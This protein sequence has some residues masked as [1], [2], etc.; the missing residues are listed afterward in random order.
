MCE[1]GE[2]MSTRTGQRRP[3]FTLVE[4]LVV[5]SII[6]ILVA[7]IMPG[8]GKAKEKARDIRCR[9]NLR[10]LQIGA[11]NYAVDNSLLLPTA[12]GWVSGT[13]PNPWW[14]PEGTNDIRNGYL[15]PYVGSNYSVYVCPSF[16]RPDIVGST[17][18]DGTPFDWVNVRPVRSYGMN[19][20]LDAGA[21]Q[22]FYSGGSGYQSSRWLLFADVSHTN[23]LPDGTLFC[24]RSLRSDVSLYYGW[25]EQ[26]TMSTNTS[27]GVQY[28]TIGIL[29]GGKG[30][31][32]FLDGHVES[33]HWSES[34]SAWRG[35]R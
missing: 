28:E 8:I 13:Q 24:Q 2:G 21:A 17:A 26:L 11:M 22:A 6:G 9:N 7:L 18:P 35:E 3:A 5:I 30:N 31:V 20:R 10:N 14:T 23:R 12:S 1:T 29:H 19:S 15:F 27:L 33:M 32:V 4:M 25:D 16:A 34:Y